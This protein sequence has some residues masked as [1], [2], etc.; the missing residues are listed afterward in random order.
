M[1]RKLIAI[2][3]AVAINCAVLAWFHAWS[4]AAVASAAAAAAHAQL[5]VVTLPVINVHP[6][7]EQLR[8]LRQTS[9]HAA[10]PQAGI[11]VVACLESARALVASPL[12]HSL[13]VVITDAEEFGLLGARAAVQ[14]AELVARVRAFLN[15]DG[16]GAAGPAL[17]FETGPGLGASLDAWAASVA[18]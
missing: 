8:Q 7:A 1:I 2:V 6:S 17:L 14:D 12:R 18:A 9:D 16:T 15:F 10:P 13:F 5:P 4:S 3:A 11:G